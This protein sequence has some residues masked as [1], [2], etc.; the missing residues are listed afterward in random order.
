[1]EE[2]SESHPPAAVPRRN[3]PRKPVDAAEKR[4]LDPNGIRTL[5][6]PTR[7]PVIVIQ[8]SLLLR[9]YLNTE[10]KNSSSGN[11]KV[12]LIVRRSK[13]RKSSMLS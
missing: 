5:E 7:T 9:A 1:M 11:N 13:Q 3:I 4:S 6:R 12:D 2:S 8:L 10:T